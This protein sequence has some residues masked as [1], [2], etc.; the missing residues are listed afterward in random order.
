MEVCVYK[1]PMCFSRW[2]ISIGKKKNEYI[3]RFKDFDFTKAKSENASIS[4]IKNKVV[5]LN[6]DMSF[7]KIWNGISAPKR[8][9]TEF[10]KTPIRRCCI[11][12]TSSYK[13]FIWMYEKEYDELLESQSQDSPLLCANA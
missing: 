10:C 8:E 4:R 13:G 1:N 9:G 11:H 5:Q 2:S 7:V 3:E 12:E 6:L